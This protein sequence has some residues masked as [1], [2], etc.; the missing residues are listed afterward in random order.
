[1]TGPTTSTVAIF[2]VLDMKD[3][4]SFYESLGFM[5]DEY[6]DGEYAWVM[7]STGEVL[8]LAVVESLDRAANRS[9]AYLHVDDVDV[10]RAKW[11][12][13]GV[14][15]SPVEDKS[16]GMREFSIR[17]PDGNLLRVGRNL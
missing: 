17:D 1:M 2:P 8:H 5:V 7:D 6:L 10:R 13:A 3:A 11:V 12:T 15:A 4:A 9:A 16:W 14:E